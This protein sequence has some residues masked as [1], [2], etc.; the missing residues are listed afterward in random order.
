[1]GSAS[2]ASTVTSYSQ[3]NGGTSIFLSENLIMNIQTL[4]PAF[5]VLHQRLCFIELYQNTVTF[6]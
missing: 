4:S 6:W 1:M 2:G 5:D 3:N